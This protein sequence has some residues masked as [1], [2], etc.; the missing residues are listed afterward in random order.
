MA[1]LETVISII[2]SHQQTSNGTV[3]SWE[4]KMANLSTLSLPPFNLGDPSGVPDESEN[5]MAQGS[6][7]TVSPTAPGFQGDGAPP[8]PNT[9]VPAAHPHDNEHYFAE[10]SWT[11]VRIVVSMARHW[12][13]TSSNVVG[14]R[15]PIV[16]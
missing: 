9:G 8:V 1:S 13:T 4:S 11:I 7:L 2:F 16:A 5:P 14:G 12:T 15:A 3:M 6:P 10:V